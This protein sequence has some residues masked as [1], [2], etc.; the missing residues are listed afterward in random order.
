M[1]APPPPS[2]SIMNALPTINRLQL[3]TPLSRSHAHD[4]RDFGLLFYMLESF[5]LL[6]LR[7]KNDDSGFSAADLG[8]LSAHLSH[9][10]SGNDT[11]CP[12]WDVSIQI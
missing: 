2:P 5:V 9:I 3:S 10:L 11:G 7:L 12:G 4:M 8:I 6:G 1:L